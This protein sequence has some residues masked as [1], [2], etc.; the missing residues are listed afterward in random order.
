MFFK[1]LL[2][3]PSIRYYFILGSVR[4]PS[5]MRFYAHFLTSSSVTELHRNE[6][7]LC[8]FAAR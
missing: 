7:R 1:R 5:M 3:A 4:L 6:P 2:D 8:A